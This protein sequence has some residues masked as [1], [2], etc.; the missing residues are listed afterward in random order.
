MHCEAVSSPGVMGI[1]TYP[2]GEGVVVRLAGE[3]DAS[4]VPEF[5]TVLRDALRVGPVRIDPR[6]VTFMDD[7]GLSVIVGLRKTALFPLTVVRGNARVDRL[8]RLGKLEMLY[9]HPT[10]S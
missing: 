1:E 3:I 6:T 5:E 8:L 2:D 4:L 10:D 7:A 9:T